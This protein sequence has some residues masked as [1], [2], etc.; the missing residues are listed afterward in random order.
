M[1]KDYLERVKEVVKINKLF[2]LKEDDLW[3]ILD[4]SKAI[5]FDGHFFVL[6]Q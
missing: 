3:E 6:Q 1:K 2:S 5:T 4:K